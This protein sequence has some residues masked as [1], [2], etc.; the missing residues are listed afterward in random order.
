MIARRAGRDGRCRPNNSERGACLGCAL[1]AGWSWEVRRRR[2]S[3][4]G[5]IEGVDG[6]G[7]GAALGERWTH[8]WPLPLQFAGRW[9]AGGG[10]VTVPNG[11]NHNRRPYGDFSFRA[12]HCGFVPSHSQLHAYRR[13]P[14]R[15]HALLDCVRPRALHAAV[16]ILAPC[17]STWN[18]AVLIAQRPCLPCPPRSHLITCH[19]LATGHC[20]PAVGLPCAPAPCLPQKC[21]QPSHDQNPIHVRANYI[22]TRMKCVPLFDPPL[23]EKKRREIREPRSTSARPSGDPSRVQASG[24]YGHQLVHLP[25]N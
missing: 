10:R 2:R 14:L 6:L 5:W 4:V 22:D 17:R 16:V 8:R 13:A 15:G 25:P 20:R 19:S 18:M 1:R 3:A 12:R 23:H 7:E 9:L 21:M 24:P 11:A